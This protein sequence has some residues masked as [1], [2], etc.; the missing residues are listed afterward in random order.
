MISGILWDYAKSKFV[1]LAILD[2]AFQDSRPVF[3]LYRLAVRLFP[4]IDGQLVNQI[5]D[6]FLNCRFEPDVH[7]SPARVLVSDAVLM[8]FRKRTAVWEFL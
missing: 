6:P 5:I 3:L 7:G 2:Q 8:N 1:S 4:P